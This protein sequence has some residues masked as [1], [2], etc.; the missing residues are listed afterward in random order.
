M[1]KL[2]LV[3][4]AAMAAF[5]F[6]SCEQNF[7]DEKYT[8]KLIG[9]WQLTKTEDVKYVNGELTEQESELA[10][11][12]DAYTLLFKTDNTVT[13]T[14]M[15]LGQKFETKYAYSVVDGMLELKIV[16]VSTQSAIRYDIEHISRKELILTQEE[17][18]NA[19]R[20]VSRFYY[21]R[22]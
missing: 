2:F 16:G 7:S 1:K 21:T 3:L 4:A 13:M 15:K 11:G 9:T 8:D 22:K 6:T 5:S 17:V 14:V 10:T 19:E 12:D 18:R 20:E